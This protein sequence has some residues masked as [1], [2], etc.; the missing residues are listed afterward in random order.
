MVLR[1]RR[2][3][4]AALTISLVCCLLLVLDLSSNLPLTSRFTTVT[5]VPIP[6][7][8]TIIV[9]HAHQLCVIVPYRERFEELLVFAPHMHHFLDRQS[10]A[11]RI[12]VMN[13]I[14][15]Y[16]FNRASLINVGWFESQSIG[17][18]YIVMHDVDLLPQNDQLQYAYPRDGPMHIASPEYH[19]RYNYTKF[20]GGILMLTME[21]YERVDGMSNKYWGWGL[22]DDEFYL[23]LRDAD[24]INS[25]QRP[26]NLTTGRHNTFRHLH[27]RARKRDGARIGNQREMS[28]KRDRV[29]GLRTVR[30]SVQSRVPLDIDDAHLTIINVQLECNLSWTPYCLSES[31]PSSA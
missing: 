6:T 9:T 11:H 12:L 10:I 8:T 25:L 16:R 24:L 21:Q 14:D 19:P 22:E 15:A 20:I 13:Q 1:R 29:S 18:D 2:R 7:T 4:F 27:Q 3:A 28:R 23:R 5:V 17:C 31:P 26:T 30:Y